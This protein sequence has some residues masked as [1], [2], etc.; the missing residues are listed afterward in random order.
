MSGEKGAGEGDWEGEGLLE[1]QTNQRLAPGG[2]GVGCGEH[3]EVWER[4]A[5][6]WMCV[7]VWDG[8]GGGERQSMGPIVGIDAGPSVLM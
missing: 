5:L 7:A 3:T 4:G 1:L 6:W 8:M 2:R